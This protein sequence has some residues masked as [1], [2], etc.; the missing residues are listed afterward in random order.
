MIMKMEYVKP[1]ART[2]EV[3]H[4]ALLLQASSND[5]RGLKKSDDYEKGEEDV[6]TF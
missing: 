4:H 6:L 1:T 3:V 5:K 2:V